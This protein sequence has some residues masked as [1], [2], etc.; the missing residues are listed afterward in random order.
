MSKTTIR[1]PT[2]YSSSNGPKSDTTLE[3]DMKCQEDEPLIAPKSRKV[4]P[5]VNICTT[6]AFFEKSL[7]T[8]F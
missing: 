2:N 1:T 6:D 5:Q 8:L 7:Q 4:M 3:P